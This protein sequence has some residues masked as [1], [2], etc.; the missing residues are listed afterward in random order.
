MTTRRQ[1]LGKLGW[2][3]AATPSLLAAAACAGST[4]PPLVGQPRS[5]P[6][7][8]SQ[9]PVLK[10]SVNAWSFN[11]P[12]T[13]GSMSLAQAFEL[14]STAGISAIDL[15]AYYL[16]GYPTVPEDAYLF[17]VKRRAFELGLSLS[18]TGVRNDFALSD[19]SQRQVHVRRVKAWLEA[20]VK[21][22]APVL[23]IFAG[24]ETTPGHSRA[25]VLSWML[26]DIE[27]CVR[28]GAALGVIVA[29]QNHNA[30]IKTAS[31]AIEIVE[32]IDSP[33]FGLVLDTGS[34][35]QGDPY[36]EIERSIPYAVNW[37]V[38]EEVTAGGKK[39]PTDLAR[40]AQ[41]IRASSY[42]GFVPI[43]TLGNGDPRAKVP[44]LHAQW[45]RALL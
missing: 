3:A 22:G 18:G 45:M 11:G 33:W 19:K 1:L 38:K 17:A 21:L 40:V 6:E 16:K 23:R 7:A 42:R 24:S 2:G 9:R 43:E 36:A 5:C 39:S 25:E 41:L 10:S 32:A 29:I 31:Q 14:C 35:Q 26:D 8:A 13:D 4:Q 34:Y 27:E 12:L 44:E 15:T 30:F 28:Y 20:A 37:Q